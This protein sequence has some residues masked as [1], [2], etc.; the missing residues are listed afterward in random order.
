MMFSGGM[1]TTLAAAQLLESGEAERLHLLTFCNGFC[2]RVESS[3][4]HV[5]ELRQH[6]GADRIIHDISYVTEIFEEMRAPLV[7]LVRKYRS[8]LVFD[9]CCRLSFETSAIIYALNNGIRHVADGTDVHQGRLFLEKP[10]YLRVARAFFAEHGIDYFSPVYGAQGGREG[11][12][13][14]L[15]QRGFTVGPP[16]LE[17]LNITN[18]LLHQPFCLA[19]IHTFFFTSFLRDAPLLKHVIAKL[20]LGVED[21]IRLREERQEVA[22]RII[23]ER[24]AAADD[25]E[26]IRIQERICTTRLCGRN[27]VEISLPRK[28]RIDV[29]RLADCWAGAGKVT[30]QGGIV[31]LEGDGWE[32]EAFETGRVVLSGTRDREEAVRRYERWVA[33]HDVFSVDA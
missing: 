14:A 29:A 24:T 11:R 21:A 10:A 31:R 27:G 19:G 13:E 32:I 3:R 28:S 4:L 16:A 22:R 15:R 8:T 23:R 17:R 26:T 18:S 12:I 30:R 2:V 7:D 33:R 25:G 9:L 5:E 20:N 6:Y 1:D